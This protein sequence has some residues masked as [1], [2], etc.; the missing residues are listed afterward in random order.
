MLLSHAVTL[1]EAR[2]YVA[3][4]ADNARTFDASVEYEHVLL[5]LD[6]IHGGEVPPIT[7]VFTDK[8]DVLYTVAEAVIE[9]LVEHGVDGLLVELILARLEDA[10]AMGRP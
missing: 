6:T 5:E 2:S 3:A 1:A 9:E 8:R 4:L 10:R 7:E